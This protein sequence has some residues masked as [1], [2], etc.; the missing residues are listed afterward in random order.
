[1]KVSTTG[2]NKTSEDKNEPA[3][4]IPSNKI[5]MRGGVK[6]PIFG[7]DNTGY[8]QMMYPGSDYSFPGNYVY[9]IPVPQ[10]RDTG[11]IIPQRPST[12]I[13]W[14]TVS[15]QSTAR[16][17][18]N[19][20]YFGYGGDIS[21]PDLHKAQIG[22]TVPSGKTAFSSKTEDFY[23]KWK[24]PVAVSSSDERVLPTIQKEEAL[25]K[26]YRR[27]MG[28]RTTRSIQ[29]KLKQYD[30]SLE[31]DGVWGPNT[32][33]A[34]RKYWNKHTEDKQNAVR[35]AAEE[36]AKLQDMKAQQEAYRQSMFYTPEAM[37][38]E[39]RGPQFS[40]EPM[41]ASEKWRM[42]SE[43]DKV[44]TL[45]EQAED[46]A[47]SNMVTLPGQSA[48]DFYNKENPVTGKP[49]RQYSREELVDYINNSGG[50][51]TESTISEQSPDRLSYQ[52][53]LG[54]EEDR[55]LWDYAKHYYDILS[56][57][58][59]AAR[60]SRTEQYNPFGDLVLNVPNVPFGFADA[61][62]N[63]SAGSAELAGSALSVFNPLTY[64]NAAG[65]VASGAIKPSTYYDLANLS[66]VAGKSFLG[67]VSG[68]DLPIS[69][70]QRES[71]FRGLNTVTDVLTVAPMAAE[72]A[73]FVKGF[74]K[75]AAP[76]ALQNFSSW[77]ITPSKSLTP[78]E[79]VSLD[80][81]RK[82]TNILN[83]NKIGS[84]PGV[85]KSTMK[86]I[87]ND[88]KLLMEFQESVKNLHPQV[89][90]NLIG[91][92]NYDEFGKFFKTD[93]GGLGMQEM[94]RLEKLG[95]KVADKPFVKNI[96]P[97]TAEEAADPMFMK[98]YNA[99]KPKAYIQNTELDKAATTLVP[100]L[101]ADEGNVLGKLREA[102]NK[103]DAAEPGELFVGSSNMSIDSYA[104]TNSRI[105]SSV[106]DGSVAIHSVEMAPLNN[107]GIATATK[108][109]DLVRAAVKKLNDE[110]ADVSKKLNTPLPSAYFDPASRNII[111]PYVIVE[112]TAPAKLVRAKIK[113]KTPSGTETEIKY[114]RPDGSDLK[115]NESIVKILG[116]EYN[117]VYKPKS[118]PPLQFAR[119]GQ[120]GRS[121]KSYNDFINIW[122]S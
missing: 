67:A 13:K 110:I 8:S 34:Y 92:K 33:T 112:K 89:V 114:V 87:T 86:M 59:K 51:V 80:S 104:I 56:D 46:I 83:K 15:P 37:P 29:E 119:G 20:N 120:S 73:P 55:S 39:T 63:A 26:S 32:E 71:A 102:F 5:T 76:A 45:V 49:L 42:R 1:M 6:F 108:N 61:E 106:K 90:R 68:D 122:N 115:A 82:T 4:M 84:S 18:P 85:S 117:P 22:L 78:L 14:P 35:Q 12:A 88:P 10:Y 16:R 70:A 91:A 25:P 31:V 105:A 66:G 100:Q 116:K 60:M 81:L 97:P 65:R 21:I 24:K 107:Q 2:Y 38:T 111:A 109:P 30:P 74:A 48:V 101:H 121:I 17:Y 54:K 3:L 43:G 94:G 27:D 23:T 99:I 93:A 62:E 19:P 57:P 53:D 36:T 98:G 96:K 28:E 40:S 11:W 95:L 64:V 47:S 79:K 75:G 72:A 69:N 113:I 118:S 77:A 103:I 44:R 9:E 41:A 50:R 52:K 7:I 58:S